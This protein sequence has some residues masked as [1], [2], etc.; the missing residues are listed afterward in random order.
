VINA[1]HDCGALPFRFLARY[2]IQVKRMVLGCVA[3]QKQTDCRIDHVVNHAATRV[4]KKLTT[5]DTTTEVDDN[6]MLKPF[7][8]E[9]V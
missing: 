6:G 2:E 4:I 5:C 3:K 8:S 1:P 9:T 7:V